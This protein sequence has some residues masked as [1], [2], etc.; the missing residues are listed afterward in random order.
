MTTM[1]M[2]TGSESEQN[3]QKNKTILH[4]TDYNSLS[5]SLAGWLDCN[6][7]QVEKNDWEK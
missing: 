2:M 3:N 1:M 7:Q 5:L 4:K 6:T